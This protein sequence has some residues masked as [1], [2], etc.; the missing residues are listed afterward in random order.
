MGFDCGQR[1]V[2]QLKISTQKINLTMYISTQ[3]EKWGLSY[4]TRCS[5]VIRMTQAGGVG[6]G[7][8][9]PPPLQ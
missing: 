8:D 7:G 4:Y 2:L 9:R 6:G 3:T 5:E 1:S